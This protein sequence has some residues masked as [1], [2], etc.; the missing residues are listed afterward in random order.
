M[1]DRSNVEVVATWVWPENL[2][3][4]AE[5]LSRWTAYPFDDSDWSGLRGG[6]DGTDTD[7][8]KWFSYPLRGRPAIEMVVARNDGDEAIS[9]RVLAG[10]SASDE[11]RT[12]IG[13]AAEIFNSYRIR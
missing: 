4:L 11:L 13:A 6:I 8:G 12:R 1:T 9:V 3:A 7:A 2:R 5:V 10:E